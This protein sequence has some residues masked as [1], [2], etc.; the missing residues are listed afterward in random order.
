VLFVC[1]R[2]DGAEQVKGQ[3]PSGK[4]S[5]VPGRIEIQ[6]TMDQL[7]RA[8]P[9]KGAQ[10]PGMRTV[11]TL[12][13]ALQHAMEIRLGCGLVACVGR[14]NHSAISGIYLRFWERWWLLEPWQPSDGIAAPMTAA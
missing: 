5:H 4:K 1:L 8:V 7:R 6:P 9:P 14:G 11:A 3:S 2:Q 12:G 10:G 13:A